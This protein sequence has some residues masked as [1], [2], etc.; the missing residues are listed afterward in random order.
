MA[1]A[2]ELKGHAERVGEIYEEWKIVDVNSEADAKA[3]LSRLRVAKKEL[4]WIKGQITLH[5]KGLRMDEAELL[6]KVARGYKP[7][8]LES[9][10]AGIRRRAAAKREVEVKYDR[11]IQ[12]HE[13]F[14]KQQIDQ[15]MLGLDKVRLQ[16]DEFIAKQ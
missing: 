3:A 2:E 7:R 16:L 9:R 4:D 8:F 6:E 5:V 10:G 14:R 12:L 15:L 1:T 13:E 11:V